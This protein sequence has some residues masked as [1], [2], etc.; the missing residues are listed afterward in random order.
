MIFILKQKKIIRKKNKQKYQTKQQKKF[1]IQKTQ[2]I[3]SMI[4]ISYSSK[5]KT[6]DKYQNQT[7]KV[8][9]HNHDTNISSHYIH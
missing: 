9:I 5:T 8:M 2:Q 6:K 7:T 4:I 1:M 3:Q